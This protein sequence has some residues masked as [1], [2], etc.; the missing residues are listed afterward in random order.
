VPQEKKE[1]RKRARQSLGLLT[2]AIGLLEG[3]GGE[4][5]GGKRRADF[6][7]KFAVSGEGTSDGGER[8]GFIPTCPKKTSIPM[9][10]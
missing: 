5:K 4:G 8:R 1:E 2:G 7:N 6:L 9:S 10:E 3:R